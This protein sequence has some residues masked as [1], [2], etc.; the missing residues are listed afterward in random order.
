MMMAMGLTTLLVLVICAFSLFTSRSFAGMF[1]YVD[2]DERNKLTMDQ[3]SRDVRQA[4]RLKSCVTN[5]ATMTVQTITLEDADGT[6]LIYSYNQKHGTLTRVKD[7]KAR[8]VLSG[9]NE[10][11]F[12]L[13]Q[14]NTTE[15]GYD[16][17]NAASPATCKVINVSWNC[18]RQILGNKA[19]TESAQTARI[20]IR[21]QG[22]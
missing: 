11:A 18:S 6:D 21:K 9:C 12:H 14:R 8:V 2:L 5:S 1:N 15:G 17:Y 13:G 20:V 10:L 3:L 22:T 19:N 4:K 16:V 7:G